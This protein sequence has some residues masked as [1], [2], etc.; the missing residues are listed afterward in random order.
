V[1]DVLAEIHAAAD[2][3]TGMHFVYSGRDHGEGYVDYRSLGRLPENAPILR[4]ASLLLFTRT[5]ERAHLDP[6]RPITLVGPETLGAQ[7]TM[8]IFAASADEFPSALFD[9]SLLRICNLKKVP[10][11]LAWMHSTA[12][13]I[14]SESQIIFVDDLLNALST[15]EC[16]NKLVTGLDASVAAIAVLGDRSGKTAADIGVRHIESLETFSLTRYQPHECPRCKRLVPIVRRPGH[17]YKF[18]Q[19]HP[20]Y[21]GGFV[22]L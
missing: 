5:I 3:Y 22:N 14:D 8:Q 10:G 16:A 19:E 1:T 12:N 6:G 17:G 7:M 2:V 4:K 21:P 9:R 18:E 20:D 13:A 11:G 15:F